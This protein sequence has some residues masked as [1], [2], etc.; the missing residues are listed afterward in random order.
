MEKPALKS[1]RTQTQLLSLPQPPPQEG[2]LQGQDDAVLWSMESSP[3]Y[4]GLLS[5]EDLWCSSSD[6]S[7][8]SQTDPAR[9]Q[10]TSLSPSLPPPGLP[11]VFKNPISSIDRFKFGL[12]CLS[13]PP[14]DNPR[15]GSPQ[16]GSLQWNS[17]FRGGV[18]K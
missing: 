18:V 10:R 14:G 16:P 5:L 8:T 11:W 4:S 3:C 6:R 2:S 17:F 9:L 7:C 13:V 15:T 12:S 1:E